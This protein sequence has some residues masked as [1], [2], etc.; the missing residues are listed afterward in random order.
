[1][2]VLRATRMAMLAV[3][4]VATLACGSSSPDLSHL[5]GQGEAG[6]LVRRT[7]DAHGGLGAFLDLGDLEYSASVEEYDEVGILQGTVRELHRLAVAPP[8]RYVLRRGTARV[9]EIGLM[10]NTAWM[11]LDGV[12]ID[13][14]E[15]AALARE[16]LVVLSMLNRAPF[17]LADPGLSLTILPPMPATATSPAL[18]RLAVERPGGASDEPERYVFFIDAETA[19]IQGILFRTLQAGTGP[20]FRVARVAGTTTIAGVLVVSR[21]AMAPADASG[22]AL[23]L[24]D[25]LWSATDVHADNGFTDKLYWPSRAEGP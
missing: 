1:M 16:E 10:G 23:R 11:R 22:Q 17:V 9:I 4:V 15:A 2:S 7:M 21:W 24:R 13:R 25:T 18:E 19:L 14:P 8:R 5:E 20:P 6:A 3:G 12:L